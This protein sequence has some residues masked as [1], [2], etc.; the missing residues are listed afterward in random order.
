M[1]SEL[2]DIII[3][4]YNSGHYLPQAIDSALAQTY[5]PI[6]ILV[7]DDGSTDN[8]REIV[9]SYSR[10]A[11]YY[12][13][14]NK[15]LPG[16]RNTGIRRTH[17]E[18]VALLDADDVILPSKI[19][20][21]ARFLTE[22]EH[23]DIVFSDTLLVW[24]DKL[25]KPLVDWRPFKEWDD[26]LEPFVLMCAFQPHAPLIRRRV[27]E[28]HGLFKEEMT[29]GCEDWEFWLRCVLEGAVIRHFPKFHALYR[30]HEGSM[31]A[32][33]WALERQETA[34]I[35]RAA[36][37]FDHYGV[38]SVR[39][40]RLLS[41][42]IRY[43]ATRGLILGKRDQCNELVELSRTV[44]RGAPPMSRDP[45]KLFDANRQVP[46]SV[47]YLSLSRELLDLERPDLGVFCFLHAGDIRVL[48]GESADA[49]E[50]HLFESTVQRFADYVTRPDSAEE[51]PAASPNGEIEPP[52][53]QYSDLARL[54]AAIEPRCSFKSHMWQ[55]LGMLSSNLRFPDQAEKQFRT[56]LEMNPCAVD[57]HVLLAETL[58]E[59]GNYAESG[60]VLVRA[61]GLNPR[62]VSALMLHAKATARLGEYRAAVREFRDA[63]RIDPEAF[64][65]ELIHWLDRLALRLFGPGWM[66]VKRW[67]VIHNARR[68]VMGCASVLTRVMAR[69]RRLV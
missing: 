65:G 63:S 54:E 4:C 15:G 46:C 7:V 53:D 51:T 38:E 57:I 43:M 26:Y 60:K 64:I 35:Q 37:M 36:H 23:V 55:Q 62:D 49:G 40:R 20:D 11:H 5:R 69:L 29:I 27:F 28:K 22:N 31:T 12:Y 14:E 10:D 44:L 21:Q 30:K 9:E 66:D 2:V 68:I 8:T 18:Y 33:L 56:A 52:S 59:E 61:L 16:A 6:N 34:L 58:Y 47:L 19:A 67:S 1:A 17:G 13:Q 32:E 24:D 48:R 50:G 45:F 3:P 25:D 39:R 42:G 41:C